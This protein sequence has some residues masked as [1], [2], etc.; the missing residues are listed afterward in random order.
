MALA[1]DLLPE[2]QRPTTVDRLV[3]LIKERNWHLST[4]F[5]G[6][7]LLCPV[8]T[9]FGRLDIAFRLLMQETY[10]GWLYPV[11]IGATT[12]WE[13]W[14]SWTPDK[15]FVE[16]G[17]NSLNHY[18][19]GAIGQWIYANLGGIALDPAK[20][21]YKHIRIA[22][23]PGG[24]IKHAKAQLRSMHGL[25]EVS[26]QITDATFTLPRPRAR[27][28]HGHDHAARRSVAR[29]RGWIA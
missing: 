17:M 20:P 11:S 16:V 27:Q 12:M 9:R 6:T 18:A 25:I 10:P 21:A 28:H 1:F 15:G 13:R 14:N 5:L 26:W 29:G 24:G 23:K 4:G 22:P 2:A 3:A 19:Y 7:P 8:L